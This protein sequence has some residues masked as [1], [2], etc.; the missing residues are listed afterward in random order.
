MRWVRVPYRKCVS[1]TVGRA[2]SFRGQAERRRPC[3][4][5]GPSPCAPWALDS[6]ELGE[7][8]AESVMKPVTDSNLCP[9]APAHIPAVI[10]SLRAEG[11]GDPSADHY[12]VIC[13]E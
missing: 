2:L 9:R 1:L 3:R 6:R 13:V 10:W 4:M 7:L 5:A 8:R 11:P 12:W